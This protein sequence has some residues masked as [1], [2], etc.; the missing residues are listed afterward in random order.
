MKVTT[1]TSASLKRGGV[2][3]GRSDLAIRMLLQERPRAFTT[4]AFWIQWLG[5]LGLALCHRPGL[6]QA[7]WILDPKILPED[8]SVV[9]SQLDKNNMSL[10]LSNT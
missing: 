8:R 9:K 3:D 7:V 5:F 4:K 6:S 1:P 10:G 2:R